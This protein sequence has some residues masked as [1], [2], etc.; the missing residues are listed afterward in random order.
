[1]KIL[2]AEDDASVQAIAVMA[3]SRVGG[4][5]V[6]TVSNGQEAL[7]VSMSE[8]FDLILLDVM[9][10]VMDGFEACKAL[11][12]RSQTRNTPVIFLTAKAQGYEVQNGIAAGALG[13]ILKPF[14][15]MTLHQ[16]IEEVLRYHAKAA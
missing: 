5:E 6:R 11:K 9:M 1:L 13:Y 8:S 7:D 14:D 2:L 15:P 10:P 12:S 3:L 16:Q 4:H